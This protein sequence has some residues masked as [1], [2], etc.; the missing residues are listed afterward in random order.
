M[1]IFFYLLRHFLNQGDVCNVEGRWQ[2]C[3]P[4]SAPEN[5][6]QPAWKVLRI[7]GNFFELPGFDYKTL[8]EVRDS[9]IL[10][11]STVIL[12]QAERQKIKKSLFPLPLPFRLRENNS[13]G[14]S[15]LTR[16]APW[17][18]FCVDNIVRRSQPLQETLADRLNNIRLNANTAFQLNLT[19]GDLVTA[20]QEESRV[21][22]PLVIDE[23]LADDTVL[24][25]SG[26]KV[27]AGFGQAETTITLEKE[28]TS[29]G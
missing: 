18:M 9:V 16:L 19:A 7:L 11:T 3:V 21:T 13:R 2:S 14:G 1:R 10:A 26:L 25:A 20:I 17:P 8:Q 24:L 15:S 6:S 4:V 22:L 12:A 29:G 23:R 27:T 28:V 5:N